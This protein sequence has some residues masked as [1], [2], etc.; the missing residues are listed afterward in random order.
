MWKCSTLGWLRKELNTG[1]KKCR[2]WTLLVPILAELNGG[3][4]AHFWQKVGGVKRVKF[5]Q[6]E[7]L[8]I[9]PAA[10][11]SHLNL[12]LTWLIRYYLSN[13]LLGQAT[14]P[15]YQSV[16]WVVSPVCLHFTS[17]RPRDLLHLMRPGPVARIVHYDILPNCALRHTPELC[18]ATY[19]RIV[20]C[21]ILPEIPFLLSL[22][23]CPLSF[24]QDWVYTI[25]NYAIWYG[26][27]QTSALCMLFSESLWK[28]GICAALQM[29]CHSLTSVFL[30]QLLLGDILHWPAS[31]ESFGRIRKARLLEQYHH[32]T[33]GRPWL[34]AGEC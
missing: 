32:C 10:R 27:L 4:G 28:S 11:D 1:F 25:A 14:S 19:S 13:K 7:K 12:H 16:C 8:T 15:G 9:A 31:G 34:A 30:L 23:F 21:D 33:L 3:K 24:R 29:P 22:S 6:K 17:Q 20:H 26:L 2:W 5:Q 18:I